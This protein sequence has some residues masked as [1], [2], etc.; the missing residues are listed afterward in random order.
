[1]NDDILSTGAGL[2]MR[3]LRISD[4]FLLQPLLEESESATYFTER[5]YKNFHDTKSL[6]TWLYESGEY[7]L[8]ER[9]S[10]GQIIGIAGTREVKERPG[11]RRIAYMLGS[12][13]RGHGIMPEIIKTITEYVL[14]LDGVETI[15]AAIRPDNIR[16]LRCIEKVGYTY[17]RMQEAEDRNPSGRKLIYVKRKTELKHEEN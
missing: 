16:S 8:V 1:M 5:N 15:E 10:D 3:P 11:V 7:F 9:E 6:V 2:Y 12:R 17:A 4:T 13:Y 14:S